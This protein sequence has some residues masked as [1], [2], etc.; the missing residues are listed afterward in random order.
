MLRASI[1]TV[2]VLLLSGGCARQAPPPVY[3]GPTLTLTQVV[4]QIN[5]NNQAIPTLY[6]QVSLEAD[7]VDKGRSR[8]I[9]TGGDIF[10]RKPRE[11]LLRGKKPA[12]GK[13]FEM[14]STQD[15]YWLT[16]YVDDATRWWGHYRNIGKPCAGQMPIR[17]DLVGEVLGIGDV[18]P[19]FLQ[20][21]LL[22]MTF[23]NDVD[24]YMLNWHSRAADRW[25]TEKSIWYDRETLLPRKVLLYD[26]NGRPILRANLSNHKAVQ[27]DA[28]P[29][30]RRPVIATDYQLFFPDSG[31][32]MTLR[33]SDMRL[34]NQGGHPRQG[35]IVFREEPDA[36]EIQIDKDCDE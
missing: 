14:G 6:A 20:P 26:A 33:L 28:E 13:V 2:A 12:M 36:T 9:N 4:E 21:P 10:V 30:A 18:S 3:R 23:N 35:T 1:L 7:I 31:S 11:L 16:T 15:R 22:T 27:T 8:F 24:V 25:I 19:D 34:Q 29:P 32:R 5:R 17:P